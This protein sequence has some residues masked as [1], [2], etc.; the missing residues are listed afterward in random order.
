MSNFFI[1][2]LPRSRTAWF[3]AFMTASG[4][5]CMHEGIN[6][7]E[8]LDEYKNKVA[9]ASDSNTGF[10]I[11]PNPYP[12]RPLLIIHRKGRMNGVE[13]MTQGDL[14]LR[15][16]NGLHVE[17]KDIDDRIEEIFNYLTGDDINVDIFNMF[18]HFNIT[19]ME[20]MNL[21]AAKRLVSETY[22]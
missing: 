11:V 2:G 5:P 9:Y 18:K 17:F 13:G 8:T 16:M 3:S 10:F 1:T 21:E 22:K 15:G 6:H 12:D 7:C 20:E 4:Y 19:T 14:R